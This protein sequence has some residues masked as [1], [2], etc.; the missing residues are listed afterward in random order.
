MNCDIVSN[1][2]DLDHCMDAHK[3]IYIVLKLCVNVK[4]T[5]GQFGVWDGCWKA[6]HSVP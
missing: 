6:S 4:E 2:E 5:I 1:K 3:A